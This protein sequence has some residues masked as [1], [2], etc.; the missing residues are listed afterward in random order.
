MSTPKLTTVE[1]SAV[2][3]DVNVICGALTFNSVFADAAET[4][5]S[6]NSGGNWA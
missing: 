3:Y 1:D 2:G 5:L 6:Y 4:A